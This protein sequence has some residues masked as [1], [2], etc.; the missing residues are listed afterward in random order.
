MN[1]K[2][3]LNTDLFITEQS[4]VNDFQLFRIRS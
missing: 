1:Q 4:F 3:G 2:P